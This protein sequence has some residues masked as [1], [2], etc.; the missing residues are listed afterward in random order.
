MAGRAIVGNV[1]FGKAGA[2]VGAMTADTVSETRTKTRHAV[3]HNYLLYLN[4]DDLSNPQRIL[5]FGKNEEMAYKAA[6][7]FNII[8]KRNGVQN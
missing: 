1:L 6:S 2:M 5:A 4:I 8:I 7:I 3:T